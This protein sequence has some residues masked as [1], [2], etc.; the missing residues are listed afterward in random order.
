MHAAH[1]C[2]RMCMDAGAGV[3]ACLHGTSAEL[4]SVISSSLS[5]HSSRLGIRLL[6]LLHR[7]PALVPA[8]PTPAVLQP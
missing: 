2:T 8:L 5:S 3:P 1:L 4:D 7:H 6:G